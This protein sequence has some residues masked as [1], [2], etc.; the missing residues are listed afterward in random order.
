MA[1]EKKDGAAQQGTAAPAASR[2]EPTP[3]PYGNP[4]PAENTPTVEQ[5]HAK[6][7]G[8]VPG[9][10]VESSEDYAKRSEEASLH[11]RHFPG[12]HRESVGGPLVAD[13][14]DDP[15]INLNVIS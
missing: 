15:G 9:V 14:K 1:D 5:I 4:R 10:P 12:L 6:L 11:P 13:D 7:P 8:D 2:Q 3:R